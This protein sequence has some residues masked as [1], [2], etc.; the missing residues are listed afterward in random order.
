MNFYQIKLPGMYIS[1]AVIILYCTLV[2]QREKSN[3]ST[4]S[5]RAATIN[6]ETMWHTGQN[7]FRT[8]IYNQN[9]SPS[10]L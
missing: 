7:D 6:R 1:I 8:L 9:E 5:S 3:A 4:S 2:K 10:L